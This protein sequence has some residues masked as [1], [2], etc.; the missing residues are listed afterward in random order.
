MTTPPYRAAP[1]WHPREDA[2]LCYLRDDLDLDWD[3]VFHALSTRTDRGSMSRYGR[4]SVYQG[5]RVT[6]S[7]HWTLQAEECLKSLRDAN[8]SYQTIRDN[9]KNPAYLASATNSSASTLPP[10]RRTVFQ[11]PMTISNASTLLPARPT[12]P[13]SPV[14]RS[15][16]STLPQRQQT[17]SQS[18]VTSSSAGSVPPP[19]EAAPQAPVTG[20]YPGPMPPPRSNPATVA[21]LGYD[22]AVYPPPP[23][24]YVQWVPECNKE[25][26][27]R[28]GRW[29]TFD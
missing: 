9:F 6:R 28:H 15:S 4:L 7:E 24:G 25:W 22:P 23:P 1:P 2:A 16:T 3:D 27:R 8:T 18:P 14:T 20:Q 26:A 21:E 12:V 5:G 10:P 29:P 19:H 13:Q 11:P 17:F